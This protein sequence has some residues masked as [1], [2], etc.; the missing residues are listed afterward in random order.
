MRTGEA[1]Y[2]AESYIFYEAILTREYFKDGLYQDVSLASKQ[3]RF[4]ARFLTVCLVSNR[5]EMVYQLVNQLKML[6]DECRRTFQVI[7]SIYVLNSIIIKLWL[8]LDTCCGRIGSTAYDIVMMYSLRQKIET[9]ET[10]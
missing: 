8:L 9:F 6:L 7:F 1:N 2:L 4:F 5:R 10:A 3:L